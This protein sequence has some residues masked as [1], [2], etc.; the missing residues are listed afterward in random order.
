[1]KLVEIGVRFDYLMR[2][3]GDISFAV[4]MPP[5]FDPHHLTRMPVF[6]KGLL[7]PLLPP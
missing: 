2:Q 4:Q 5:P 1:M 3:K 7:G 6:F